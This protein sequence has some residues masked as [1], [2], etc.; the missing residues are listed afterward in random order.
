M[1][2]N[3][4]V[5][6]YNRWWQVRSDTWSRLEETSEQLADASLRDQA[7]DGMAETTSELL[8]ALAPIERYWAF[9]GPGVFRGR[10]DLFAA[11]SYHRFARMV[12]RI[13]RALVTE[14][15]RTGAGWSLA[16]GH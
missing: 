11:A 2:D 6:A 15:Y 10:A 8:D 4:G 5:R 3:S 9:P 12:A 16:D 7:A 14:S 1:V 13:S